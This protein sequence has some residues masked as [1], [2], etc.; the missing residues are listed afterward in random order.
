[1][2]NISGQGKGRHGKHA[3]VCSI[4]CKMESKETAKRESTKGGNKEHLSVVR[5]GNEADLT[6]AQLKATH[7][8]GDCGNLTYDAH[9]RPSS[10]FWYRSD[11]V[12]GRHL[13]ITSLLFS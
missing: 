10:V 9:P 11:S 6:K 12:D 8:K 13:S 7:T 2:G 3:G 5:S 4:R 1:M